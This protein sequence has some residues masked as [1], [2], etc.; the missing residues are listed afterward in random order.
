MYKEREKLSDL[1]VRSH[2]L[3]GAPL[4]PFLPATPGGPGS[5]CA[6]RKQKNKQRNKE[7][8]MYKEREKL[9]YL[10]IYVR[11][12]LKYYQAVWYKIPRQRHDKW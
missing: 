11:S 8:H 3:T 6:T 5:P 1:Y 2:P 4:V 12:H 7:I 9:S 10:Y